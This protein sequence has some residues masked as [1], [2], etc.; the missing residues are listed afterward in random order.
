MRD[1][2]A[3]ELDDHRKKNFFIN[4]SM[5]LS[6]CEGPIETVKYISVNIRCMFDWTLSQNCRNSLPLH[7]VVQLAQVVQKTRR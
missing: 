4:I 5:E 1:P 2:K 7:T 3:E 6:M